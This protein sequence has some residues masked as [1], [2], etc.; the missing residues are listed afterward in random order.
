MSP[1][2]KIQK[3][4]AKIKEIRKEMNSFNDKAKKDQLYHKAKAH[5][6]R[7][8]EAQ[9]VVNMTDKIAQLEDEKAQLEDE[10]A[11]LE[12]ENEIL[13]D[14]LNLLLQE[15]SSKNWKHWTQSSYK[16]KQSCRDQSPFIAAGWSN[17]TL[18]PG[19]APLGIRESFSGTG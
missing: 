9:T 14:F 10:N 17:R 13:H 15:N 8:K 19:E 11:I 12:D 1:I 5:E 6:S 3:A 18:N 7:L 16:R 2:E 4:H